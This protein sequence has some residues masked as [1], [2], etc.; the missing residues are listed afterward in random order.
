M[1]E[2][3]AVAL[4]AYLEQTKTSQAQ[5][6]KAAKVPA[7]T[8]AKLISGIR[9]SPERLQE[10]LRAVPGDEASELLRAYLLDDVPEEWRE[11]VTILVSALTP[12]IIRD[13]KG[14]DSLTAALNALRTA[15]QGDA[16]LRNWIVNTATAFRLI[17]RP[18]E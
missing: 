9:P 4:R 1:T 2:H 13:N 16:S 3:F 14:Q 12:N 5:L 15:A 7:S 10:I 8:V 6:E 18:S 11:S 17:E